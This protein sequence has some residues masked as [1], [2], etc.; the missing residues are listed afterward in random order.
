MEPITIRQVA[1]AEIESAPN[2]PA[3]LAEYARESANYRLGEPCMQPELYRQMEATG[4]LNILAAYQ[5]DEL[6][7]YLSIISTVYPHWGK[8]VATAE[9]FFV[10][11]KAR[12]TGAGLKL[13][14]EAEK[15][16]QSIGASGMFVSAPAHGRLAQVLPKV[17]FHES[18]RVFYRGLE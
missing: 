3:L 12:K 4:L 1:F 9:S 16:A 6:V 10:T 13:L 7:G 18:N 8:R 11:E 14:R 17:G 2:L 15:L 5:S